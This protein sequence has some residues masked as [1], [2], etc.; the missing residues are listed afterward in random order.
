LSNN[1]ERV[2][3]ETSLDLGEAEEKQGHLKVEATEE[4]IPVE[5]LG[6]ENPII[7]YS[8][9]LLYED[10]LGDQ[11]S[12]MGS[13]RFRVMEDCFFVLLRYYLRVDDVIVRCYDTR[14]FHSFDQSYI[15]R[16]F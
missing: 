8:E 11:G 12:V 9:V 15:L 14:I 13:L 5:R 16:E 7:H 3:N 1:R 6:R 4:Q 2:K 10:D